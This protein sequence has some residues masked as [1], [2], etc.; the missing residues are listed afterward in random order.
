[1]AI[2]PKVEYLKASL[3]EARKSILRRRRKESPRRRRKERRR[4]KENERN[5]IGNIITPHTKRANRR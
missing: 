2:F 1:M 5:T 3:T 4:K